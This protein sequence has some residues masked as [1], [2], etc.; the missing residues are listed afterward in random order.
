MKPMHPFKKQILIF[1]F[2]L[3]SGLFVVTFLDD[4]FTHNSIKSEL[5]HFYNSEFSNCKIKE[6]GEKHYPGY[7][8]NSSY[9]L[10]TV[11]CAPGYFPILLKNGS[12]AIFKKD[13]IITKVKDSYDLKIQ[14]NGNA[15]NLT[16]I[17]AKEE[18][19]FAPLARFILIFIF[20]LYSIIQY[21]IP[22]QYYDLKK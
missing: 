9:S 12:E 7:K 21:F 8:S 16:M 22:D 4:D 17:S 20:L 10:F 13:Q 6:I 14:E 11:D 18:V 19:A 1:L 3:L 2:I 5:L 15:V